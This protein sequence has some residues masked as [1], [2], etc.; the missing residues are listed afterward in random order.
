MVRT[1]IRNSG[2]VARARERLKY[3]ATKLDINCG[4]V[5]KV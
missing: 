3:S 4:L 2:S 5:L 1:L